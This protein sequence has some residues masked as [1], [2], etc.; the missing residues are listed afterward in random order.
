MEQLARLFA[1]YANA[2]D[3]IKWLQ[4]NGLLASEQDAGMLAYQF[5]IRHADPEAVIVFR[6]ALDLLTDKQVREGLS[7]R[8]KAECETRLQSEASEA[9]V[10][11]QKL[12]SEYAKTH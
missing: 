3:S 7:G 8:L 12:S 5:T 10:E 4:E 9:L 11:L 2:L 6:T 1:E